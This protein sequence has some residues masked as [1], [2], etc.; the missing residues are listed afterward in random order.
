MADFNPDEFLAR[1]EFD[2][3][4]YLSGGSITGLENP[5][6]PT[7][8]NLSLEQQ[9]VDSIP[10]RTFSEKLEGGIEAA[11]TLITGSTSGS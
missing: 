4:A 7:I 6:V 8:E 10:E 5:D 1:T 11:K 9:R 2:P 3:D